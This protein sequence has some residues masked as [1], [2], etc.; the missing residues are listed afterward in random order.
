MVKTSTRKREEWGIL[1]TVNANF[2]CEHRILPKGKSVHATIK[3][4]VHSG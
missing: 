3:F 2:I 1:R 4:S